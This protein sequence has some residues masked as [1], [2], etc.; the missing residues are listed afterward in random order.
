[1]NDSQQTK[2]A[3]GWIEQVVG[4]V[5]HFYISGQI[6]GPEEYT[7]WFHIIRS[8]GAGDHIYIHLN[9]QGGNAFTTVQLMRALNESQAKVITSAEGLV[10]SAATMIFLCGDQCEVS[11]HSAFMFHTFSSASFGKS[12]EMYAQVALEKSWGEKL[13]KSVYKDFL[14]P[15]EVKQIIAGQDMW[16]ETEEV[17]T[18]LEQRKEANET[19]IKKEIKRKPR[20]KKNV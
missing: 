15:D 4:T 1:M 11:D 12:S 8:A 14:K 19:P 9:S 18:R 7:D 3:V 5:H 20:K 17:I 10:A 16:M 13:L 6:K 2:K